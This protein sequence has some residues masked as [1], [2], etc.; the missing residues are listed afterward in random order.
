[1]TIFLCKQVAF[2][3]HNDVIL[4]QLVCLPS[5]SIHLDLSQ[6]A[7]AAAAGRAAAAEALGHSPE[8]WLQADRLMRQT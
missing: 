2:H 5:I 1:M 4:L 7:A 6:A 8:T 3:I